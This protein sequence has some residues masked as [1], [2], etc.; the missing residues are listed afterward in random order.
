MAKTKDISGFSSGSEGKTVKTGDSYLLAIGI[1][2]YVH[3]SPLFNAVKDT[4]DVCELLQTRFNFKHEKPHFFHLKNKD[5]TRRKIIK[6][7]KQLCAI[8]KPDDRVLIFY[9]GHGYLDTL[10]NRGYW[11]P[12]DAEKDEED[13]YVSNSDIR[14]YIKAMKSRHTLL[15]S[16]SCFSGSLLVR[17]AGR[18]TEYGFKKWEAQ[19]SRWIFCSGKGVVSDGK[20]G[21][22]SPFAKQIMRHLKEA[23]D[24]K[25]NIARLADEVIKSVSFN[26]DQQAEASPMFGTDHDGGQFVFHKKNSTLE[27]EKIAFD[28]A[29]KT[30]N[31]A[32]IIQFL[33]TAK[34][35]TFK[36]EVRKRL[37]TIEQENTWLAVNKNSYA[38]IDEFL[39]D[40]PNSAYREVAKALMINLKNRSENRREQRIQKQEKSDASQLEMI[41]IEGGSFTMGCTKEQGGD[42]DSNEKPAHEVTVPSFYM[43]KYIVTNEDFVPF[44]NAKGNQEEGGVSWVDL[45]GEYNKISCGIQQLNGKFLVKSGHERLPMIYVSWYGARA[46]AAWLRSRTGKNYRLPSEAEWEYAARG[47]QKSKGYKYAGSNTLSEVAWYYENSDGQTHKVGSA[48]KGNELGLYDMSGNVWEWTADCYNDSYNGAPKDGSAWTD[49]DGKC[50]YRVLRGGSWSF[51][52]RSCRTSYRNYGEPSNRFDSIGFRLVHSQ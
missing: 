17:N 9:S 2:D 40:N 13:S 30:N 22:N 8:V 38:A 23:S 4:T 41:Y 34:N 21:Q 33:E 31:E 14:D 51:N 12:V 52:A 39:D 50:S 1:D 27:A 37:R 35:R 19:K 47:G 18:R 45:A 20:K 15:I 42:C 3:F 6:A 36:K 10:T 5:A 46:Y 11:I 32:E 44:L 25:V 48:P 28:Q 49:E 29:M 43:G 7:L 16:D 24:E 26:Y